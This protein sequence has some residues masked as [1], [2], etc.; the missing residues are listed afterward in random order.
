MAAQE[1]AGY[2][3]PYDLPHTISVESGATGPFENLGA[4]VAVGDLDADADLDIVLGAHSGRDTLL[5]NEGNLRFRR[6]V[7][8]QGATRAV[9]IVDVNGDG[10][11]DIVTTRHSGAVDLWQNLG[12]ATTSQGSATQFRLESLPGVT[13]PAFAI[14]WGDLEGDGDLDLVAATH[15]LASSNTNVPRSTSETAGLIVYTNDEFIFSPTLLAPLTRTLAVGLVDVNEDNQFDIIASSEKG[16]TA[17]VWLNDRGDWRS[18]STTGIG[19]HGL[20]GVAGGDLNNDGVAE[21]LTTGQ[22]PTNNGL[23]TQSAAA[24]FVDQAAAWGIANTG[25]SWSGQ[26]GD[27]ENDGYLD[28]YIV[29]GTI[30]SEQFPT[31]PD[32]EVAEA[33]QVF[34]NLGGTGFV[35]VP[36][37]ELGSTRSGRGM[38]IADLDND[39]DLDIVINNLRKP[40][41]L[42]ENRLCREDF[43]EVDLRWPQQRNSQGIGSQLTLITDRATYHRTLTATSGYLA[44]N[45][46]RLHFG[47]PFGSTLQALSVQWPDGNVTTVTDLQPNTLITVNYSP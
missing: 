5:W 11:P 30:D 42:F 40:A 15:N 33:N 26:L 13:A 9:A 46:M 36:A 22:Q 41:Q 32:G 47:F 17:Q 31:L 27:F 24:K 4:G 23:H 45:P 28:L 1:C 19:E 2:F 20:I 39:G 6:E 12:N 43:L 34:R 16:A 25:W 14:A 44:G 18:A 35:A 38:V 29:N 3:T 37:W 10:W 21:L 8:G 7:I